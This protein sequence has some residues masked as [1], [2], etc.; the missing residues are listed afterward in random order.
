MRRG[1]GW[2]DDHL[3]A[4][5]KLSGCGLWFLDRRLAVNA[6]EQGVMEG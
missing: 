5:A 2:V 4:S 1:I 3:L 6:R